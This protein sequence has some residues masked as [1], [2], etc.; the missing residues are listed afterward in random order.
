MLRCPWHGY[1]YGP[2][3]G[4]S[5]SAI[6]WQPSRSRSAGRHLRRPRARA[7]ARDDGHRCDRRDAR[8]LGRATRVRDGRTLEPGPRRRDP[9][10]GGRGQP[11]LHRDPTRGRR[12]VRGLGLRQAH[13]TTGCVSHD[14]RPRLNQPAHRPV[15]RQGRPRAGARPH[16]A[17]DTQVLGPGAFQEV[18]LHARLRRSPPSARRSCQTRPRRVGHSGRR[19][20]Q[21]VRREVAHLVFPDEVQRPAGAGPTGGGP[22]GRVADQQIAPPPGAGPGRPALSRGKAAGDH[23]GSW[24]AL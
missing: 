13:R 15:G 11:R 8:E 21:L 20:T 3:T 4:E 16:R 19:R 10:P 17:G 2:L 23:R 14:C 12:R 9:T 5:P 7:A 22:Q 24:R 18:D 6:R 1:D